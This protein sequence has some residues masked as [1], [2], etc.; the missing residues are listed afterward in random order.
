MLYAVSGH[1]SVRVIFYFLVFLFFCS[2]AVIAGAQTLPAPEDVDRIWIQPHDEKLKD[3]YT[4]ESLLKA[5]PHLKETT[6]GKSMAFGKVWLWQRG[7]IHLKDGKELHWRSFTDNIILIETD[8]GPV[9]YTDIQ[10]QTND[11]VDGKIV[12]TIYTWEGPKQVV[13]EYR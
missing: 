9:F 13:F 3:F 6:I 11:F 2:S 5:L 7:T 8:K 4:S 12:R 1:K 10:S